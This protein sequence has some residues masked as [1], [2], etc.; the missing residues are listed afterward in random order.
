ML[1][2]RKVDPTNS[3]ERET[4]IAVIPQGLKD[5]DV[6]KLILALV[7]FSSFSALAKARLLLLPTL[8]SLILL[9]E[10]E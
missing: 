5:L 4:A 3:I 6:S 1:R 10:M 9:D 8:R 7:T 2:S